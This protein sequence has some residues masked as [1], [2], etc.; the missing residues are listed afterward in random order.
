MSNKYILLIVF[1][2]IGLIWSGINPK[3]QF[4]WIMEVFPAIIGFIALAATY[5]RFRFTGLVYAFILIHCWILFIGGHYTYAEMPL[6]NWIRDVFHQSRNNYD[7]VGHFFQGFV[8]A[9]IARELLIRQDV[10]KK[11]G[12]LAVIV[13]SICA[14]ISVF[15][16]FLEWGVAVATGEAAD[17]FLGTQ[18]YIWDTQSDMLYAVIGATAAVIFFSR[19]HDKAIKKLEEKS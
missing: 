14:A 10:V 8:P 15:Y 5:K 18:G 6:F 1:F 7:K 4:T 17:A 2:F 16:E 9:L 11:R 13:V 3:D 19:F 12:W